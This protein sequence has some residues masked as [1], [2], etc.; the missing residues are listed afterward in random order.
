MTDQKTH[1]FTA[2]KWGWNAQ[3]MHVHEQGKR[4][5]LV[6]WGN[7]I[8]KGDYLIL[9]NGDDSTRYQVEGI[10]YRA[11]PADMWFADAVF[12]PRAA[13]AQGEK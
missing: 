5:G 11:D 1:D 3:V 9:P 4:L 8:S 10:K 6:G 2:T 7:G 12:A 13:R